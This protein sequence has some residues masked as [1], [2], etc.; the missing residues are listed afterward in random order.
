MAST[1]ENL[2]LELQSG[3]RK[4]VIGALVL[5]LVL[6]FP[7]YLIGKE[8]S[9]LFFY[10]IGVITQKYDNSELYTAK[11]LLEKEVR[12]DTTTFVDLIN[13]QRLL[14]SFLDNRLNLSVGYNRFVYKLQILDK[15][16][17]V[18]SD[19][20]KETYLLPGEAK[21]ITAY[22]TNTDATSMSIEKQP[23]TIAVDYNPIANPLLK[24]PGLEIR[25]QT[26]ELKDK[27]TLRLRASFKNP[28]KLFVKDVDLV[29][30]VRDSQDLI[31]GVQETKFSGFTAGE[32][33][34]MDLTYP[35]SKNR[36][37]KYL[38]VRYTVNYLEE[39]SIRVR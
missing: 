7:S 14:Y 30:I 25:S 12:L 29:M 11:T 32:D 23:Q 31:I 37:A 2:I 10:N 38:D 26:V 16:G 28:T 36:T 6:A 35:K 19:E 18:I 34:D 33:R 21:I 5:C 15:S 27:N 13:G 3:I 39:D 1:K 4:W 8:V 17:S 22:T 20:I 24:D 9:K